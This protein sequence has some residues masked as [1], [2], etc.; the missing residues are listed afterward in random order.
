MLLDKNKVAVILCSFNPNLSY[1]DK[2]IESISNQKHK[3]LHV[4]IFDDGTSK[5]NY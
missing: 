1:F 3:N 2:Q 4:Y 5:E